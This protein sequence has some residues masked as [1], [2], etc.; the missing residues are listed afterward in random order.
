MFLRYLQSG[1]FNTILGF[2]IVFSLRGMAGDYTANAIAFLVVVPIS[3]LSHR[4]WS[5][6]DRNK[7]WAS[8]QR[9]VPVVLLGYLTN[10]VVLSSLLGFFSPVLVQALAIGTHVIATY[11]LFKKIVF[12]EQ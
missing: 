9:F 1:V 5:F 10:L 7:T 3:F 11:F 12:K 2:G 8:F 6:R 4:D